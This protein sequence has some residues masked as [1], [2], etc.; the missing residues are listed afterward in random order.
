M[1]PEI[2][3]VTAPADLETARTL[4]REYAASLPFDLDFQDFQAELAT[5]PGEYA[6]PG[7]CI[8]L[9]FD[10]ETAMGCVAVRPLE[11]GVCEMKRLYVRAAHRGKKVGRLLAERI[12][13]E[14][15]RMGYR[16][17]RL[18]TVDSMIEANALYAH[19]GFSPI[20]A[21]RYNPLED[22]AYFELDLT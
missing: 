16:V 18:D 3:I 22:A 9:A 10:G 2:R 7:G 15:R 13:G 11:D 20:D 17:M 1:P 14:A 19:L 21:Y 5:L 12:I 8:L 6:A 4:F